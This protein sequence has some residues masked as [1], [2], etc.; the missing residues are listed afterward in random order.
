[1]NPSPLEIVSHTPVWVWPLLAALIALG[2]AQARPRRAA[3]ARVALLPAA[4]LAWSLAGVAAAFGS[5]PALLAWAAAVS[6]AAFATAA[7]GVAPGTRW[8]AVERSFALPGSWLPLALILALFGI[9]FASGVML[10]LHPALRADAA[11]ASAMSFAYGGFAGVFAGRALALL[12]LA[13]AG[14]RAV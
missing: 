6:A 11:F 7:Q 5:A 1:M 3:L 4:M 12:R 8:S 2:A 13:R 10:A 9:K 14:V